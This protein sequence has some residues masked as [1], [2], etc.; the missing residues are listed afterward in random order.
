[1]KHTRMASRA[2]K[3]NQR[4][5]DDQIV[6][7][8]LILCPH[9][10]NAGFMYILFSTF[11]E[12]ILIYQNDGFKPFCGINRFLKIMAQINVLIFLTSKESF[13]TDFIFSLVYLLL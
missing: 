4:K 9:K 11:K 13:P 10:K 1:M 8:V 3:I 5:K 7:L 12:K 6:I 2:F